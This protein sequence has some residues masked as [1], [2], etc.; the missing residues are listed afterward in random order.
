MPTSQFN[1]RVP[2]Q[3]HAL[4]RLIVERLRANPDGADAL[5]DALTA[6]C[7]Q[8]AGRGDDYLLT[9]AGSDAD[10]LPAVADSLPSSAINADVEDLKLRIAL[11]PDI[12]E[13]LTRAE[14][15]TRK[16]MAFAQ[17]INEGL[18][19]IRQAG[20]ATPAEPASQ[21]EVASQPFVSGGEGTRRL[22]AGV[23]DAEI[24]GRVGMD[25]GA[26]RQ[27]RLKRKP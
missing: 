27:R 14:E 21:P 8:F 1:V 2:E 6:V 11:L 9:A 10:S 15:T 7:R 23:R 16:V 5:A 19:E 22:R 4:L 26:I 12:L 25:P 3:Y 18:G 20:A 13:R 17:S 24:A